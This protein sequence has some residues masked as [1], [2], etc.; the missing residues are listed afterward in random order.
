ML[1]RTRRTVKRPN[2]R[3][4]ADV[5]IPKRVR[6]NIKKKVTGSSTSKLYRLRVL[7]KDEENS[8]V[9]VRYIGYSSEFDEWRRKEDIVNLED[10]D[11]SDIISPFSRPQL[12]VP[13]ITEFCLYK[14]LSFKI[15]SLLYSNRKADPA[16]SVVMSF[17]SVHFEGLMRRGVKRNEGKGKREVYGLASLTKLDDLLGERWY[18]RGLNSAGDFCYIEPGTV[19]YYLECCKGKLDYQLQE[20]GSITTMYFGI[21]HQFTYIPVCSKWCYLTPMA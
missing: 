3:E 9:R 20:D 5:K 21:R 12:P 11:S 4:L 13:T 6:S 17:D 14:E 18:I 16:C 19:K 1:C 2:Y 8:R 10:D 7:D 15:K